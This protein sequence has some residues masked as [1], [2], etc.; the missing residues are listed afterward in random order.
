M[1]TQDLD[2]AK[3]TWEVTK[4]KVA[5]VQEALR[6]ME[7]GSRAEDIAVAQAQMRALEAQSAL[8]KH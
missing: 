8:L 2:L 6:L 5:E 4:A 3:S 7:E 1:S